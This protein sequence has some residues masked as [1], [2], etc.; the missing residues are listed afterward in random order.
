MFIY[1]KGEQTDKK[2]VD[3][4]PFKDALIN[5]VQ[6]AFESKRLLKI[7]RDQESMTKDEIEL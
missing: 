4:N 5:K 2:E 1:V 7:T 6:E 3:R